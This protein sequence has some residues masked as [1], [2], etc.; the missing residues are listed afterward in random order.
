M[1]DFNKDKNYQANSQNSWEE[2]SE[3]DPNSERQKEIEQIKNRIS[4]LEQQDKEIQSQIQ[5]AIE[6][7]QKVDSKEM[8]D[9]HSYGNFLDRADYEIERLSEQSY[10]LSVEISGLEFKLSKLE[11]N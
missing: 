6:L 2:F 7:T 1:E 4:E 9:I 5:E 10:N 11:E 3:I 8:G